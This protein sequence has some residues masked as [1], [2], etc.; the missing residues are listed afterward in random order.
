MP[1][2][3]PSR[4]T[5]FMRMAVVA[6]SRSTCRRAVVGCIITNQD[7]TSIVS[8][9]YNG[10]ARGL[11]DGCDADLQGSCGCLHAEENALIK[12]PYDVQR[13]LVMFT[14]TSPC[15][16]CAKRILNS[17]V[18]TVYYLNEYRDVDP[19]HLLRSRDIRVLQHHDKE[20]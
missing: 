5:M 8:M 18:G 6:A 14:T 15:W 12:A 17:G 11:V 20:E 2:T 9:G 1:A 19:I 7:G 3:R 13:S 10:N 4:E 16:A